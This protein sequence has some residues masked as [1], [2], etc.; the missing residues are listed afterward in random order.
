MPKFEI[1]LDR[2][3]GHRWR[4][5]AA[6]GEIVAVSESYTTRSA[7]KQSALRVKEL[8]YQATLVEIN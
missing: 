4:L 8:A 5:K 6:N 3:G 2:A 1:Y 7:A